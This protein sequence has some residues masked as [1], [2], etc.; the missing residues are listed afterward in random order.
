M[1]A[2]KNEPYDMEAEYDFSDGVRGEFAKQLADDCK[3]VVLDPDVAELFG[4]SASVNAALR[5]LAEIARQ[6]SK[7]APKNQ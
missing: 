3:V 1:K 7:K 2:D 4:D 5:S 6:Q